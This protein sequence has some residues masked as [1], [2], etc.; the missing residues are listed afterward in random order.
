MAS[1]DMYEMTRDDLEKFAN[2]VKDEI[3]NVLNI[4]LLNEHYVV[5]NKSGRMGNFIRKLFI[6]SDKMDPNKITIGVV[7]LPRPNKAPEATIR[8]GVSP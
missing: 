6:N 2:Q 5:V 1:V 4:P 7:G 3:A 8:P